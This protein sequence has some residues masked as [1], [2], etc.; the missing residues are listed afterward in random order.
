MSVTG[1]SFVFMAWE[2]VVY[3]LAVL[4]IEYVL[5][6]PA[7]FAFFSRRANVPL[8]AL[9]EEDDDVRAERKR[10][11]AAEMPRPGDDEP[12]SIRGLRKVYPSRY[13]VAPKI[14]VHDLWLGVHSGEVFGLLGING[15][16]QCFA[17]RSTTC[18]MR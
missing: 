4:A 9:P 7:L 15:A 3:T 13:G 6:T 2:S 18:L 16:G 1:W 10:L 14:A 17:R 11:Q 8:S 5:E 12:I